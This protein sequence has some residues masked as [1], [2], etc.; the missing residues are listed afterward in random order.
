MANSSSR[1]GERWWAQPERHELMWLVAG[2]GLCVLLFG[3]VSLAGEV[4]EGDTQAF[5]TRILEALR[6]PVDRSRPIG[7]VWIVEPL[8]DLTAIGGPTVL[9]LVVVVVTGFF[10]LQTRYRTALVVAITFISGELL[11]AA[12]KHVF[13]RPRPSV[14]PHLQAVYTT[15]FPSGHAMESAIVYLTLAAILMR[16]SESRATKI[17]ILGTA[18]LLTTLV[19]ISRVYL[20]VH[21]PTDVLG[22]WIVGFAWASICWHAARRLEG[23]VHIQAEKAKSE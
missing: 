18:M 9:G 16:A 5:D 6:D 20:G 12:M 19:G 14:V 10:V 15:S 17:Y 13:N 1:G 11:N 23:T 7:P 2:L 4:A 22:G 21:Y 3:F 8:V